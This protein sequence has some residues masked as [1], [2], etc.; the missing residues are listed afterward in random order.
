[1]DLLATYCQDHDVSFHDTV[2]AAVREDDANTVLRLLASQP[3][4]DVQRYFKMAAEYQRVAVTRALVGPSVTVIPSFLY[5]AIRQNNA[6]MVA[7]LSSCFTRQELSTAL[8]YAA[9]NG[10]TVAVSA[11][12]ASCPDMEHKWA[13][14]G[15]KNAEVVRA[16][17]P[18]LPRPLPQLVCCELIRRD[19]LPLL[20]AMLCETEVDRSQLLVYAA[21]M[22]SVNAVNLLLQDAR[23]DPAKCAEMA[24]EDAARAKDTKALE[25]LLADVRFQP[26]TAV[27][28]GATADATLLLLRTGRVQPDADTLDRNVWIGRKEVVEL[29]LKQYGMVPTAQHL[30]SATVNLN[31]DMFKLL[32]PYVDDAWLKMLRAAMW[33]RKA[34]VAAQLVELVL[35]HPRAEPVALTVDMWRSVVNSIPVLRVLLA[36]SRTVPGAYENA[37]LIHAQVIKNDTAVMMLAKDPRVVYSKLC[38]QWL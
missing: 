9:R 32:L 5:N 30:T 27:L 28:N 3:W 29:L 26:T 16:L 34:E 31:V 12:C 10:L 33:C 15:A 18:H 24:L 8:A 2:A 25:A 38:R 13:L 37:A 4:P 11:L 1:M 21:S 6:D 22:S 23:M 19:D 14:H 20:G 35:Q 36:D 7:T 17:Y